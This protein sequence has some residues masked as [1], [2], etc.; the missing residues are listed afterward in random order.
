MPELGNLTGL[1]MLSL[2]YPS[3]EI[4]PE[5]GNL[6]SLKMLYL[7]GD[8]LLRGQIPPQLCNLTNLGY[9]VLDGANLRNYGSAFENAM[10]EEGVQ[11]ALKRFICP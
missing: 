1:R 4:P 2:P 10:Y 9:L 11:A 3:G 7:H 8:A 5:L 6:T